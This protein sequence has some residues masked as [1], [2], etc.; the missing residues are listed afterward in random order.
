[1]SCSE[2]S[3]SNRATSQRAVRGN[4]ASGCD[5]PPPDF[6]R[7]SGLDHRLTEPLLP[8]NREH[9]NHGYR[10]HRMGIGANSGQGRQGGDTVGT[11]GSLGRRVWVLLAAIQ[12]A[13]QRAWRRGWLK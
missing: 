12:T 6:R 5:L 1:M 11:S 13:G 4:V 2:I 10:G 7:I 9:T 3:S 8:A